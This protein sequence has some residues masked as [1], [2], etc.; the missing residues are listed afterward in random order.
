MQKNITPKKYAED[1][2]VKPWNRVDVGQGMI[3][4]NMFDKISED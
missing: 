2:Y 3:L 4:K 1:L